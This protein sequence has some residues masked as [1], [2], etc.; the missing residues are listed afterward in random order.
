[1]NK[2]EKFYQFAGVEIA[3]ELPDERGV[4]DERLLTPFAAPEGVAPHRF[5]FSFCKALSGPEG[6]LVKSL[7]AL[8][9]YRNGEKTVRYL[10]Q[11]RDAWE[12]AYYRVESCGLVN[13]VEVRELS[14]AS[15]ITAKTILNCIAAEHLAVQAGGVVFHSSYIAYQ[16]KAIL[17]TAPSGTGKSTQADLW[18]KYRGAE[19]INGDRSVIRWDG[20]VFACGIPFAGS[21]AICKNRTLPLAAIVYLQQA[22]VT[23]I[24][25]L[26][27]AEAFRRVWEGCSVNSW[28]KQDMTL[29]TETVMRVLETVPVFEL[30]CTPDESAVL[31]LEGVLKG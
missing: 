12:D 13:R 23:T 26:R 20:G 30:A 5:Q 25:K 4:E 31:A 19:I 8:Q 3:V 22:P 11:I 15:R 2:M 24:R 27:G 9:V 7:P 16:G 10:S 14:A 1:M 29:A 18:E 17:F 21:S 6:E 28:D